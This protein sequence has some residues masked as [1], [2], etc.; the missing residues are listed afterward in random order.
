MAC[1]LLESMSDDEGRCQ[2]KIQ[3]VWTCAVAVTVSTI[4]IGCSAE[5]DETGSGESEVISSTSAYTSL[6]GA[7]CGA[8]SFDGV[9][10]GGCVGMKDYQALRYRNDGG[11]TTVE[12]LR[13]GHPFEIDLRSVPFFGSA[14]RLGAKAEWRGVVVK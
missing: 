14:S 6:E 5:A 1:R 3:S 7:D 10:T 11:K 2:M 12:V 9:T 8:Q 13:N 4:A